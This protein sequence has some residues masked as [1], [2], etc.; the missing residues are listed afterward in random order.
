MKIRKCGVKLKFEVIYPP[1]Y[2][3]PNLLFKIKIKTN[4]MAAYLEGR[5]KIKVEI[6]V[7]CV[8]VAF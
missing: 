4:C 6:D 8:Y 3:F 2:C 1:L 5:K 7:L